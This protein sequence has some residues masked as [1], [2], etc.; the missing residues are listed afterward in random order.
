VDGLR[1][2]G[3]SQTATDGVV[4]A[5]LKAGAALPL[6]KELLDFSKIDADSLKRAVSEMPSIRE[7]K[8]Q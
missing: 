4:S 3:S 8:R 2:D 5:I 7:L 6:L 1:G